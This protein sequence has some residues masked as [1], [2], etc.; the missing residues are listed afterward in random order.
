[1]SARFI[2]LRI[3]GFKSFAD[4]VTVDI[5]PGLTGIVG[6]NGCGKSN[7]V[8]GLRWAMGE[9]SAR[10]L[11]GGE[12]DDL[13]FAGTA[14][15]PAR[16]LAEVT[17]TLEN[18]KG[19]GPGAFAEQDDLQVT[20]RAERGEGS[21]YR[22]NGRPIRARDV[23]TLFADLA[24]GAQS[25]AMVSQG[26]V[27][28]LV[29]A[30]PEERRTILEE[31]AG[32]TGLHARRH[33]AELK[34]RATETNLTRAEDLRTQIESRLAG[35][36]SQSTQASKYR[37]LSAGLREAE[38]SLLALLH[39]RARHQ[40]ERA[41]QATI[42]ARKALIAAEEA[43]ET[44]VLADYEADKALPPLREAAETA[45]TVLERRRVAAE[46]VAREEQRA[47]EAAEAAAGR[48]QQCEADRDAAASRLQDASETLAR[49]RADAKD[50]AEKQAALPELQAEAEAAVLAA[51]AAV[52]EATQ[53]L[54]QRTAEATAAKTR[55]EQAQ[56]A[57][58]AATG[59]HDRLVQA[60]TALEAEMAALRADLPDEETLTAA[61][62]AVREASERLAGCREAEDVAV[63]RRTESQ[64]ALSIARN[65]AQAARTRHEECQAALTAVR[66]RLAALTRD[67]EALSRRRDEA[68]KELVP[69]ERLAALVTALEEAGAEHGRAVPAF[70]AAESERAAAAAALIEAR[71][72]TQEDSTARATAAE[73]VRKARDALGRAERE[74]ATLS[75]EL[76]EAGRHAVADSV[77]ENA[78]A[79][80]AVEEQRLAA[81][82]VALTRAEDSLTESTT[83]VRE[84]DGALGSLRAELTRLRAQIDGLAQALG[85]EQESDGSP[86]VSPVSDQL[87][88]P[89]GLEIALAAALADGLD[90]PEAA[91]APDAPRSWVV[92]PPVA[93][94]GLPAGA[95]ALSTLVEAPGVLRRALSQAGLVGSD[96]AGS[97]LV[98][99]LQPGQ[100]LVTRDGAL[101]RWDGYR[102][103]AGQPNAAA[104]RLAQ[105]RTLRESQARLDM[106][107]KELPAAERGAADA[108]QALTAA[109]EAV[110]GTRAE[111]SGIEAAL[112]KARTMEAETSRR[113][114]AARARM[115]GV[116]PQHERA[117]QALGAA[118]QSLAEAV[119][120][121]EALPDAAALRAAHE[122]AKIR[123]QRAGQ[124]ETATREARR[125]AEQQ[126]ERARR[127]KQEA[128][129]RHGNVETR[130]GTLLPDLA[131][132]TGER[133]AG[134]QAVRVA[135][136]ALREASDPAAAGQALTDAEKEAAAA[137]TGAKSARVALEGAEREATRLD[138]ALRAMQEKSLERKTRLSALAPRQATLQDDVAEAES[139]LE[140]AR[141]AASSVDRDA[142]E[143]GLDALRERLAGLRADEQAAR[144][145]RAALLAE[146]GTLVAR[147]ASL[148]ASAEEWS[149][150]ENVARGQ[151]EEAAQRL[152][153]VAAEHE[154]VSALPAEAQRL[155]E[156][157]A[158]AL[159]EAEAAFLA[160][161]SARET[162]ET[163]QKEAQE[164]RRQTGSDLATARET[165]LR[166]EGKS[167]QARAIL[168]QLLAETPEPP[169][170]PVGD[171]TEAAE[172][173][174]RRKIGRLAR[175]RDELGPVNLRADIEAQEAEQ[176]IETIRR[177]HGELETAIARLRGSIGALNKEGRERLMAVFTQV[178]HH[179]QSLFSRM[180]GGGKAHLG[181]VG[182]DDPL[183]AGLEIYAQPPGKKLATL[184]LLSGGEQ[185]L[186]A[187]SLI[188]AVFRCNPAPI[189]VL[190]EVDAPLDDANV[191]RFCSLL[192]D[193]AGEAGTRFLVVTHH[194]LTMAHM[195]RLFG[196]TM[197]ERGVSRV[198]SV[199]LERASAM[200]GE[201]KKEEAHA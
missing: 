129:T 159:E 186:T 97:E 179:F 102:V 117:E 172:T 197:Q 90:A 139:A 45:R 50:I 8:E 6:P 178:D 130:L 165:L 14:S 53:Q 107:A 79:A 168:D 111:R 110:R 116:R 138:T 44:A 75:R 34:L 12:M 65:T 69:E 22:L 20:R 142:A 134:E 2:Q 187:L 61:E 123:E 35:L 113:H 199:D 52:N 28:M 91:S 39:A 200:A 87:R 104:Q 11:R 153:A 37:E 136:T 64:L 31:A 194:Q 131:R 84:K 40:V 19:L 148:R 95:T 96:A 115:D 184:S 74:A 151:L 175:E 109:T 80:R 124:A 145:R 119:T 147:D 56:A 58:E 72:R 192:G 177:E 4:P 33:E 7:V 120:V 158:T 103:E 55:A 43:A 150:R 83:L 76:E 189:C 73:G 32:I 23:Q 26:R 46:G 99:V 21:D 201:R 173:G 98:S 112:G 70:E 101:W 182:S 100:C 57:L 122:A 181:L 1:M 157:S 17:L 68:R 38:T 16:N 25:S 166:S 51:Q 92:L 24:S 140:I 85:D 128:E 167:E 114:A 133:E 81:A 121:E 149:G 30:R 198:L 86:S 195:D 36:T 125:K 143:V 135:E 170:V 82:E 27:A 169:L 127:E 10:S 60:R 164:A 66:T 146:T 188:F 180:F 59:R 155:R 15:R 118:K 156:T 9:T 191:G 171:L 141:T 126:L 49:L 5:L 77:L 137:E 41:Q 93:E 3:A 162:A 89:D 48:L 108:A 152:A 190:D 193:M 160:C 94:P 196:V 132:L 71:A 144:E 63:L 54:E 62:R 163:R 29:G 154:T 176:Q 105:R 161:D 13:I 183:Q 174:L 185:A 18:A 78:Q 47:A 42:A 88:V 106:L 67:C